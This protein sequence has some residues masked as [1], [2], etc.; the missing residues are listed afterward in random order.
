MHNS[1]LGVRGQ[2]WQR[3]Q[4]ELAQLSTNS[5]Q[6]FAEGSGHD[7]PGERPDVVVEAIRG[8]ALGARL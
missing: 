8:L 7:V 1:D 2:R 6:V 5:T 3:Y 4:R